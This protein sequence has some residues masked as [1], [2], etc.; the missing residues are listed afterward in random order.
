MQRER[1]RDDKYATKNTESIFV[2]PHVSI[3]NYDLPLF[4]PLFLILCA[5][6]SRTKC[7]DQD[8][9]ESKLYKLLWR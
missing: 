9:T 6:D 4:D 7:D 5:K 3:F 2:R 8:D 1:V